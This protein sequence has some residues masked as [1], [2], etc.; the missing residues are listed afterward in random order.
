MSDNDNSK[1][2][3]ILPIIVGILL[4]AAIIWLGQADDSPGL[5]LTGAIT[6]LALIIWGIY[7]AG[8]VTV[9]TLSCA[10][11]IILGIGGLVL[12]LLMQLDGK[13]TERPMAFPIGVLICSALTSLGVIKFNRSR[14]KNYDQ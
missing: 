13:F 14:Q 2:F 6:A 12:I 7:N 3:I 1:L 11:P 8:L 9:N 5:S 10:L 4:G